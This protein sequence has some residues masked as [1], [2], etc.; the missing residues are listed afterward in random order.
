MRLRRLLHGLTAVALLLSFLSSATAVVKIVPGAKCSKAGITASYLG[1]KFTCQKVGGLLKWNKG[2][3]VP[4]PKVTPTPTK[5]PIAAPTAPSPTPRPSATKEE[6]AKTTPTPATNPSLSPAPVTTEPV[7]VTPTAPAP[8]LPVAPAPIAPAPVA[9]VI[10]VPTPTPTNAT[11]V[12]MRVQSPLIERN[13]DG[14]P[15]NFYDFSTDSRASDW[16][17][18][19]GSQLNTY[20][21]NLP[22]GEIFTITWKLTDST[23]G[24]VLENERVWLL[25]NGNSAGKQLATFSYTVAGQ[26]RT[27]PIND[28]SS[29]GETQIEGVT[30]SQ[31]LVTFTLR[32]LNS[33]ATADSCCLTTQPNPSALKAFSNIS[34]TTKRPY[35]RENRDFL[36]VDFYSGSTS[37]SPTLLWSDEFSGVNGSSLNSQYWT[38]RYCGQSAGNGGGTCHN[39]ESQYFVP[40]AIALDGSNQGNAVITTT[41]IFSNPAAG[42]CLNSA[43][44]CA[45]TSGRFDTQGKVSFL[46]GKIDARIKMPSGS[47]NWAAFWALGTNITTDGWPVSGELDIAEQWRHQANRNSGAIHYSTGASGCCDNH[48]YDVGDVYGVDYSTDFHVYSLIWLPN[49]VSFAVDGV[50]FFSRTASNVRTNLWPFNSPIF[51]IFNNAVSDQSTAFNPWGGWTNSSMVI[52]YVRAYTIDGVGSVS[53]NR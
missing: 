21:K 33:G 43:N 50:T 18:Y 53:L 37:S 44:S 46:Y 5:K 47:G 13:S 51:L 31:G 25:V 7:I 48:T 17:V 14:S 41:H 45:F 9:P 1:K 27:I 20:L 26:A 40:E 3:L 29:N 39:N 24:S 10:S 30:D 32:N 11:H 52:D 22:A 34:L 49:S 2:V 19:Y 28:N 4:T 42:T 35:T 16:A 38:A 23:S 12:T 15:K 36:W 8:P 6:P